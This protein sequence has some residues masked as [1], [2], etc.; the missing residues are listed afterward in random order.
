MPSFRWLSVSLAMRARGSI[1]AIST[2]TGMRRKFTPSG[3]CA[4]LHLIIL[5][6]YKSA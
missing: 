3:W 4:S 1:V 6:T 5:D 2:L